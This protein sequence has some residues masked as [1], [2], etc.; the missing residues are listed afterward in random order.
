MKF[1]RKEAVV[2]PDDRRSRN[3]RPSL[4]IALL[5]EGDVDFIPRVGQYR[6]SLCW[7]EVVEK[8][9]LEVEFGVV[10][11]S[12]SGS[13]PGVDCASGRPPFPGRLSGRRNH[14]VD[15]N[16]P[17]D[18]NSIASHHGAE[19]THRLR[20][21]HR[22]ITTLDGTDYQVGVVR[23]SCLWVRTGEVNGNGATTSILELGAHA[24]PIGRGYAACTRYKDEVRRDA[25]SLVVPEMPLPRTRS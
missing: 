12:L 16:Q 9:R 4:D 25:S 2:S 8:I 14:C 10:S 18:W 5:T 7:R 20:H 11:A 15:Q 17:A 24:V 21:H 19:S 6:S 13:D 1:D 3:V 22:R 23:K